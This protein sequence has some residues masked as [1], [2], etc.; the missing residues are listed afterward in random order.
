MSERNNT[1]GIA[2]VHPNELRSRQIW[3]K[4]PGDYH[5]VRLL[6]GFDP[7]VVSDGQRNL[8]GAEIYGN[9]GMQ[10]G[11]QPATPAGRLPSTEERDILKRTR[12]RAAEILAQVLPYENV[13]DFH[14]CGNYK[15]YTCLGRKPSP[16]ALA[17]ALAVNS[18]WSVI[19]AER[20]LVGSVERGVAVE[21]TDD[22]PRANEYFLD[23]LLG[24][25]DGTLRPGRAA[26]EKLTL[27]ELV[28]DID[29]GLYQQLGL[30]GDYKPFSTLPQAVA[31]HFRQAEVYTLSC[32]PER[33]TL[34]VVSP[35]SPGTLLLPEGI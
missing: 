28:G 25:D 22:D 12:K 27:F 19:V 35:A 23:L 8:G 14:G 5:G 24:V 9:L 3:D 6:A 33:R 32:D 30:C 20:N 1:I 15:T 34:E 4:Y 26:V 16:G 29:A 10:F 2:R 21:I 7:S 31:E 11:K 17:V 13:V 18:E